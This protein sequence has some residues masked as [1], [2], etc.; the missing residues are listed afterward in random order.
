MDDDTL[1]LLKDFGIDC[2]DCAPLPVA[3]ASAAFEQNTL[4][5]LAKIRQILSLDPQPQDECHAGVLRAQ[6]Q[7]ASNQIAAQLRV[8]EGHL[9]A[10]VVERDF[11]KELRE[12]RRG[13]ERCAREKGWCDASLSDKTAA[14][15]YRE[16]A[17]S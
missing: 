14:E 4:L 1:S 15:I 13:I 5:A 7:I 3:D 10:P 6:S 16:K 12:A 8:F 9:K 2:A 17:S 11:H